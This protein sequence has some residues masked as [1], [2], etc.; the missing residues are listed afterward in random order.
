[1]SQ[2]LVSAISPCFRMKKYLKKFLEE[3]PK[4]TIFENLEVILDHNE[5][6]E[7]E[8]KMIQDFQNKY[9][10][11]LKHIIIPKVEPIGVSMN[12][13]IKESTADILTIWNIDDLR[14]E[15]SLELQYNKIKSNQ[16]SSLVYGDFL[17]V[18]AFGSKIGKLVNTKRFSGKEFTRSMIFGPFFM[19]RKNMCDKVGYFDEQLKSGADFDFCMRLAFATKPIYTDGLLGYYLNEGKGAS[20]RP[21]SLQVVERTVIEMRYGIY[22]K[23]DYNYLPLIHKYSINEIINFG[24]KMTVD[25]FVLNYN[26]ILDLRNK[27]YFNKGLR[28]NFFYHITNYRKIKYLLKKSIIKILKGINYKKY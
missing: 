22:D 7:E 11:H 24:Q 23:V 3:L 17:I 8:I 18:R 20:T 10:N 2:I 5:P 15:N 4:Q 1:M 28:K 6:D 19:F 13:C 26:E 12:R 27:K 9:P 16:D 25:N 14:T 21:G